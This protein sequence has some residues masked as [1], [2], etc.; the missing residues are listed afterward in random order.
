[1]P[2]EL[3]LW[4]IEGEKPRAIQQQKLDLEARIEN[5]IR[6]D[7]GLVNNDLLIIGQQV[8]TA[9]G[10]VIDL[11][12]IDP[13]GNLV[14]LELKKDKTPRDIVAQ[15]LDYASWV[16][17]LGHEEIQAISATFLKPKTL[18]DAFRGKFQ[19]DLPDVLNERHRM[20]VVASSLDAATERIVKYLSE[21]HSVDIN[22]ATFAYYKTS[23]GEFLGRS[24]LLDD[25][26]VKVRADTTSKRQPPRTF[27]EFR[28]M[29]EQRG[30][31]DLYDKAMSELRPLFDTM[32]RSL[33]NVGLIGYMR[34]NK[35]RNVIIGIYPNESS[36]SDGLALM[37]IMDRALEYFNLSADKLQSV[38]GPTARNAKTYNPNATFYMDNRHLS[39]LI[40]L[41]AEAKKNRSV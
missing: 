15:V 37:I 6:D 28:Q 38:L 17:K 5:W 21:S 25:E 36:A 19:T 33:T 22:V 39:D 34:E 4:Q 40:N 1:V 11:L 13:M 35:T 32:N 24:L 41:L 9:Y 23:D 29:A 31:L 10:G 12:A 14:I 30:V 16:E 2:T 8:A 26:Q 7:V 3:R 27:E 18:E 20:Y